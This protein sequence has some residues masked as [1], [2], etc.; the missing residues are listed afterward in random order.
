ML[1]V[2]VCALIEKL[3]KC[4]NLN[5]IIMHIAIIKDVNNY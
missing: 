4:A 5:M 3:F 1:R 2:D